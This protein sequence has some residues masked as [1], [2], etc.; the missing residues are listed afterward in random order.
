MPVQRTRQSGGSGYRVFTPP[1]SYKRW[2]GNLRNSV[3]REPIDMFRMMKEDP[4]WLDGVRRLRTYCEIV[5]EDCNDVYPLSSLQFEA[6]QKSIPSVLHVIFGRAFYKLYSDKGFYDVLYAMHKKMVFI[7]VGARR[8]GKTILQAMCAAALLIVANVDGKYT[9][10]A[11]GPTE[12]TGIRN[13]ATA[14]A[15]LHFKKVSERLNGKRPTILTKK[16]KIEV[17]GYERVYVAKTSTEKSMRGVGFDVDYGDE[18]FAY[19]DARL[20]QVLFIS[21]YHIGGVG[22]FWLTTLRS[23]S[24]WTEKYTVSSDVVEVLYKARI[25]VRCREECQSSSDL[26]EAMDMCERLGHVEPSDCPWKSKT[27]KKSWA[28]YMD[29]DL[30]LQELDGVQSMGTDKH[31]FVATLKANNIFE[32][33]THETRFSRF[34][35]GI[36]P[37][38]KGRSETAISLT[39]YNGHRYDLMA[40][41]ATTHGDDTIVLRWIYSCIEKY[42]EFLTKKEY[43]DRRLYDQ[44]VY[45]WLESNTGNYGYEL[46]LMLNSGGYG[47]YVRVMRGNNLVQAIDGKYYKNFGVCKRDANTDNYVTTLK[48]LIKKNRFKIHSDLYTRDR[49]GPVAKKRVLESQMKNFVEDEKGKLTG[50]GGG[51]DDMVCAT[52]TIPHNAERSQN[53]KDP[54]HRQIMWQGNAPTGHKDWE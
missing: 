22:A 32:Q 47:Y 48:E 18:L 6:F 28:T 10:P 7:L 53:R 24:G 43:L 2:A 37:S 20:I 14:A 13:V 15:I 5:L 50:K 11:H 30:A 17:D 42:I 3:N 38:G 29:D 9:L 19:D 16:I 33:I 44:R 45:V 31:K 34:D 26:K 46:Q 21:R 23:T 8:D 40:I 36:D 51:N 41:D 4:R 39:G 54:L 12:K 1:A 49:R 35:I 27:C 25:C 52:M